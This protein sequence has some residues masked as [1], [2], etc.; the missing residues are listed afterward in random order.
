MVKAQPN[1]EKK[2]TTEAEDQLA[3]AMTKAKLRV[4]NKDVQTQALKAKE[5]IAKGVKAKKWA[6][7]ELR[8]SRELARKQKK[9]AIERAKKKKRDID[10]KA[11]ATARKAR[12]KKRQMDVEAAEMRAEAE[13][14]AQ[15]AGLPKIPMGKPGYGILRRSGRENAIAA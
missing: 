6:A 11:R 14:M 12:R 8:K 5:K 4:I 15:D 3:I 10:R 13:H 1:G 9:I 7:R 2:V